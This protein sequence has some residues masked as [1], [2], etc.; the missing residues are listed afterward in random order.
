MAR[1]K[2]YNYPTTLVFK[3]SNKPKAKVKVKVYK[4]KNV[5]D[6]IEGLENNSLPGVP[7][8]AEI[9]E[10]GVGKYLSGVYKVQH[11]NF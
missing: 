8:N 7:I 10:L 1:E 9:I 6:I 2:N 4:T 5:D 11:S 3:T